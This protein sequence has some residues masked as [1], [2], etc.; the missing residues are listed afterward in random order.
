MYSIIF[1]RISR[2]QSLVRQVGYCGAGAV[3]SQAGGLLWGGA[4]NSPEG[5][6]L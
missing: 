1:M 2:V 5:G 4:V 3:N 6:L